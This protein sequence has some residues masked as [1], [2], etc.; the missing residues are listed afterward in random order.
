M[1]ATTEPSIEERAFRVDGMNCAS[2]VAHVRKSALNVAGVRSAD[3]NL[4]RGRAVI[5]FDPAQTNPEAIESA[6]VSGGYT[7]SIEQT[8]DAATAER[9]RLD[10][11]MHHA[12][13]WRN[14]AILGVVLWLP[15]EAA[16]WLLS[17]AGHD[18]AHHRVD[19][20]TWANLIASTVAM[21][22]VGFAFYRSAFAALKH[23]TTNM[24][25]L[26]ALGAS[27]AWLFSLAALLGFVLHLWHPLPALYFMEASGLL[28]LIS[29]GHWLEARA[30]QSAGSAIRQLLQLAPDRAIH[31]DENDNPSEVPI[32]AL[33]VG[34]RLLVRPNDRIPIDGTI[35]A[36][37]SSVDESM[38]TGEPL[39]VRRDRGDRVIGGTQNLDGRLILRVTQTGEATALSQ[40]V[41]LVEQAQASR[42]AIQQLADR[43]AA[44]FVPSVLAIAVFTGV[45]WLTVGLFQHW[46]AA[47]IAGKIALCVCSVLIIACPCALGLAVPAALM[48]GT[49]R[50]A[51]HGI[52]LRDIDALQRAESIDTIAL[53]KTGTLT[54]GK[55]RIDTTESLDP[56]V[57]PNEAI[58]IAAALERFSEHPIAHAFAEALKQHPNA[59]RLMPDEFAVIPGGGVRGNIAGVDYF[60]GSARLL[61]EHGVVITATDQVTAVY[62]ARS[63]QLLARFTLTDQI[64]P[65][66]LAAI[67]ELRAMDLKIVMLS[68]D[69]Q[70]AAIAIAAQVGIDEARG[71]LRPADKAAEIQRLQSA[72]HKLAMVGDGINDAPALAAADLAIAVGSGTDIAKQ[73]SDI[74]LVGSSLAGVASAIRLSRATMRSIRVNLF[75]AFAYNVLAIPLAAAGFLSPLI[76]AAAM[77]LSDLTV[78]GNALRLRRVKID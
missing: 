68:G 39:P 29:I 56:G 51:Q 30:R 45:I 35:L 38:I 31:L 23:R 37:P 73:S 55:P 10:A 53:D 65:E 71:D 47:A 40:I 74:V 5:A 48:V 36:G 59:A 46:T 72:G 3:V 16:H 33:L 63:D 25:T 41:K 61:A 9:E 42:P 12:R 54:L 8:A 69:A 62:L 22:L 18:A 1:T 50:G 21:T 67:R 27:V 20:M 4:A 11:Q 52:L 66:S 24:D 15:L 57:S 75:F 77:A 28:A 26:I 14:R 32:N 7:A 43:I 34:D 44:V 78:L 2:C 19:A 58:A 76:A 64:K 17:L 70:P 49:G 6:I 60:L 13:G